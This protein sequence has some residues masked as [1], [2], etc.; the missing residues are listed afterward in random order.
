MSPPGVADSRSREIKKN[1]EDTVAA[2]RARR[3]ADEFDRHAEAA[4][5]MELPLVSVQEV[6]RLRAVAME[7]FGFGRVMKLELA[8]Q[9]AH[10]G[11]PGAYVRWLTEQLEALLSQPVEDANDGATGETG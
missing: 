4:Q 7:R 11:L 6:E 10:K 9:K 5:Q 2:F 3:A 1:N 8:A